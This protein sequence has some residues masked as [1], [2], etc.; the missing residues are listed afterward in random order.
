MFHQLRS[1]ALIVAGFLIFGLGFSYLDKFEERLGCRFDWSCAVKGAVGIG[2]WALGRH[3]V[4]TTAADDTAIAAAKNA[5]LK[6]EWRHRAER[7]TPV[8]NAQ[9]YLFCDCIGNAISGAQTP[10]DLQSRF[11]EAEGECEQQVRPAVP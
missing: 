10:S 2:R 5:C 9:L 3:D 4:E 11:E 8:T 7:S 1:L 6:I